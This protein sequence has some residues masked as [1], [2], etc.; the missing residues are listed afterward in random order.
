MSG[1]LLQR[2]FPLALG[3]IH[4]GIGLREKGRKVKRF[5]PGR[6]GNHPGAEAK[7]TGEKF[8]LFVE[9]LL[10]PGY[11]LFGFPTACPG[12]HQE[13]SSPP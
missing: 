9:N 10:N 12:E 1:T 11:D 2:E 6:P 5:L 3:R 13:N 4:C 8:H 7:G